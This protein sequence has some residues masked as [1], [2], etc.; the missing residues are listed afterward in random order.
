M[1]QPQIQKIDDELAN[2]FN[3]LP[4]INQK[5]IDEKNSEKNSENNSNQ[6]EVKIIH[7]NDEEQRKMGDKIQSIK[8]PVQQQQK[9]FAFYDDGDD[10]L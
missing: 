3:F 7:L 6:S 5:M 4:R 9:Q 8:A 10:N 1:Q 2:E